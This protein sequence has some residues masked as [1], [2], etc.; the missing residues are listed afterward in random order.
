MSEKKFT[1]TATFLFPLLNIPKN[2]FDCNIKDTWGRLKY[3]TRFINAYLFDDKIDKYKENHIF[4]LVLNYQ[5]KDFQ[6][7]YS[8]IK[9]FPN[10]VDDYERKDYLVIIF[11]IPEENFEDF[12]LLLQGAYSKISSEAKKAILS[13]NFYHGKPFTLP[14]ILNK[15]DVLKE[16]WE[17]RLSLINEHINSPANLLDQEVWPIMDLEKECLSDEV[18]NTLAIK[19]STKLKIGE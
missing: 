18:F 5:D 11:S 16:S 10:Y 3:S 14:L 9:A 8:T 7:F 15:A 2:I 13:N 19:K 4:I 6:T 1:K 12:S 17:D